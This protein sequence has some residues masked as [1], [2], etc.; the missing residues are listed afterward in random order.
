MPIANHPIANLYLARALDP[1]IYV[2]GV[3]ARDFF[4]R[5]QHYTEVPDD[6]TD[7]LD[8]LRSSLGYH[9]QWPNPP[10]RNMVAGR[11]VNRFAGE[12]AGIRR[13]AIQYEKRTAD[14][15]EAMARRAFKEDLNSFAARSSRLRALGFPR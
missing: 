14:S 12:F 13:L 15:G 4:E 2:A 1:L 7:I 3:I 11:I 6:V 10:Q 5:P 8:H 9:P